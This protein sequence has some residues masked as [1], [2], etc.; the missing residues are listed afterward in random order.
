MDTKTELEL[1]ALL[2][3]WYTQFYLFEEKRLL[4]G[5]KVKEEVPTV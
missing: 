4:K 3:R 1:V 2:I 5:G